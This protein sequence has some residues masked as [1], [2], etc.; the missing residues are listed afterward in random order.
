MVEGKNARLVHPRD[1]NSDEEEDNEAFARHSGS[2]PYHVNIGGRNTLQANIFAPNGAIVVRHGTQ[3][4]GAFMGKWM[5]IGERVTLALDSAFQSPWERPLSCL[6]NRTTKRYHGAVSKKGNEEA[7]PGARCCC[8]RPDAPG[9]G[10]RGGVPS[11]HDPIA[12]ADAQSS[13]PPFQ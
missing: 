7:A 11:H 3:A 13:T 12:C 9:C 10:L 5:R 6:G 1:D 4:T 2:P 8:S